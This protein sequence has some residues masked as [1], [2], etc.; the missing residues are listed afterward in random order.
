[1]QTSDIL[2]SIVS[3]TS[4]LKLDA[5]CLADD[6]GRLALRRDFP[7]LAEDGMDLAERELIAALQSVRLSRAEFNAKP[8]ESD[9]AA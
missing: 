1:M 7:T 3:R 5:Q 2:A 6:V 9:G 8:V 4:F